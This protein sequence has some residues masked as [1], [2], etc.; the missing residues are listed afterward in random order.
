LQGFAHPAPEKNQDYDSVIFG[1]YGVIGAFNSNM[2]NTDHIKQVHQKLCQH[3][4]GMKP[5]KI[6]DKELDKPNEVKD[7]ETCLI[8]QEYLLDPEQTIGEILE[9]NNIKVID[10][11]RFECGE[12]LNSQE[13]VSASASGN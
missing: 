4:I 2:E 11:Q 8:Y 1:K 9:E 12:S 7:D 10:F 3:I 5:L 13:Q 6:G